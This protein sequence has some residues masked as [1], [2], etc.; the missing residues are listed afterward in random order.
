MLMLMLM[1]NPIQSN[2]DDDDDKCDP[3]GE[4]NFVNRQ[5]PSLPVDLSSLAASWLAGPTSA[6][7][8]ADK[9][10][11]LAPNVNLRPPNQVT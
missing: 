4:T 1:C 2:D 5:A 3:L 6:S 10:A 9:S 11:E 7:Q 8:L